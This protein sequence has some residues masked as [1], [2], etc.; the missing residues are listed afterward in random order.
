MRKVA[1]CIL[2]GWGLC[3]S[4]TASNPGDATLCASYF[5][6]LASKYPNVQLQASGRAVG[7]PEG[8]MGNSEVGHMT[9]GLGRAVKQDLCLINDAI[10][11]GTLKDSPA[12]RSFIDDLRQN[13]GHC[14]IVGLLSDG[15]VHSHI[16]HI[17]KLVECVA[18]EGIPVII[19]AI[20]DGRDTPPRSAQN[21]LAAFSENLPKNAAIASLCGRFYAMDRDHRWDRTQDAYALIANQDGYLAAGRYQDVFLDADYYAKIGD[22]FIEPVILGGY[23]DATPNDG[24]IFANF[25]ADRMRQLVQA[26]GDPNFSEFRRSAFP[27]FQ[28]ILS[29][30]EYDE[31]FRAFCTPIFEKETTER[32]LGEVIAENNFKQARIAETEKYAHVTFFL[33]GG[34]EAEFAEE[35]RILFE[36]P[37]VNTYDKAP[38]M[39]ARDITDSAVNFMSQKEHAFIVFN[40]ANAD[41]LG[42][43]GNF[44]ATELGIKYLDTCLQRVTQCAIA[45]DYTLLITAD[46]G[47]AEQM[48]DKNGSVHTAHTCNPVPFI[49]VN[50][51]EDQSLDLSIETPG[52]ANIAPTVLGLLGVAV[53]NEMRSK[54]LVRSLG[55]R[56]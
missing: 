12:L 34:R 27:R 25:R 49:A 42:H 43:T 36:S 50:L 22:E 33:N 35:T 18:S 3:S 17:R 24:I 56:E 37:K 51:E 14:H 32:S 5:N 39:K 8:Q 23:Y 45:N 47:N 9:I 52:L 10:E 19:H 15:G 20:L 21:F 38:E 44:A 2:D 4:N 7:L 55:G 40:Y 54:S 11:S 31:R 48:L 28:K 6:E 53:P 16:N 1:L 41:M 29:M 13:K 46:H 26:T 30:V